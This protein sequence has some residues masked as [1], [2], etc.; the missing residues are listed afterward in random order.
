MNCPGSPL[1]TVDVVG[2]IVVGSPVLF[3]APGLD[4]LFRSRN[5][6]RVFFDNWGLFKCAIVE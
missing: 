2:K 5:V 4:K 6:K 1:E 3:F